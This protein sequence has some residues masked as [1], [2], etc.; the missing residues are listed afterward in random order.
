VPLQKQKPKIAKVP[1]DAANGF[2]MKSS[3]S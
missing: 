3:I 1:T 2:V